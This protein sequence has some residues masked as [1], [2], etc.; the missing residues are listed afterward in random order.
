MLHRNCGKLL[1]D[2][3]FVA[4]VYFVMFNTQAGVTEYAL[5]FLPGTF[6]AISWY[7]RLFLFSLFSYWY[8]IFVEHYAALLKIY[9]YRKI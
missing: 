8:Q 7:S 5:Y 6:R 1:N 2:E 3:I 9:N 4:Q